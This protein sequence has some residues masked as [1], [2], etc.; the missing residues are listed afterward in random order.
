MLGEV[1]TLYCHHQV[2]CELVVGRVCVF[3]CW[4]LPLASNNYSGFWRA[5]KAISISIT[6][7]ELRHRVLFVEGVEASSW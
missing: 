7:Y 2:I 5:S 4:W 6:D 3:R 1:V